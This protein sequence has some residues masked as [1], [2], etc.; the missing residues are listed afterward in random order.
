MLRSWERVLLREGDL[1]TWLTSVRSGSPTT[2]FTD[3]VDD[4]QGMLEELMTSER[5]PA[6][7]VTLNWQMVPPLGNELDLLVNALAEAAL[8]LYPHLYGFTQSPG[9]RWVEAEV[10]TAA[11][12]ITRRVPGVHGT[13]C[14]EVLKACRKRKRPLVRGSSNTEQV[15]QLALAIEPHRLAILIAVKDAAVHAASLRALAQGVEWLANTTRARVILVLPKVLHGAPELDH[16][17]YA[18]CVF[19]PPTDAA[20]VEVIAPKPVAEKAIAKGKG[21]K[22]QLSE[23]NVT[24]SPVLGQPHPRSEAEKEL[25]DRICAD[26]ELCR[27][28]AFNQH[29]E[30]RFD[31]RPRV[32]LLSLQHKLV[33]EIDGDDHRGL[34][35]WTNDRKRDVELFLSGYRVMRFATSSV[36]ENTELVLNRIRDAVALLQGQENM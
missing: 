13:A 12:E 29:V 26:A 10:E 1:G 19:S 25:Y 17:T 31:S 28:F 5:E 4:T 3:D 24:V 34:L 7:V 32:D 6:R 18:G 27:F 33:I 36:V 21:P 30:T 23:P 2:V 20:N 15:R 16:V 11:H 8:Q 14:R 22:R 35:K 9:E